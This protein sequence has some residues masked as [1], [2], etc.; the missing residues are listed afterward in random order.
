[1]SLSFVFSSILSAVVQAGPVLVPAPV[2]KVYIPQGFD[3]NDITQVVVEGT[4]PSGCYRAGKAYV[5]K[6][7]NSNR[8]AFHQQAY[9]YPTDF[10]QEVETSFLEAID[11]G[12]LSRGVYEV[13]NLPKPSEDP[14]APESLEKVGE[15]PV[16]AARVEARD[17]HLYAPVDSAVVVKDQQGRERELI[18]IGTFPNNC[19][20]FNR[21]I[22]RE[23]RISGPVI[24][25]QPN[26]LEVLPI[27]EEFERPEGCKKIEDGF[28]ERIELPRDVP[29]GRYL[30]HIR[31]MNGKSFNK[32]DWV[33]AF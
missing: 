28:E 12:E 19:M 17:E 22:F 8:I 32:I 23:Q 3:S 24:R 18:L 2:T 10:C 26:I 9:F 27:I 15:L 14:S 6:D 31:T 11:V 1:M 16:H 29:A 33:E 7:A 4:F 5:W 20:R 25:T 13:Y 30:F 21:S